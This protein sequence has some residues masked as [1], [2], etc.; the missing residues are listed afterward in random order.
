VRAAAAAAATPEMRLLPPSGGGRLTLST[1]RRFTYDL[2]RVFSLC[3]RAAEQ[4]KEAGIRTLVAL[5]DQ[6]GEFSSHLLLILAPD[7]NTHITS[8]FVKR[9]S[10][11]LFYISLYT[12]IYIFS[13]ILRKTHHNKQKA[14]GYPHSVGTDMF[15]T[16]ALNRTN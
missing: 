7:P 6:G 13:D 15:C 16:E 4:S 11:T 9:D 3:S 2:V 8:F 1:P 10:H 5:D 14:G 12:I